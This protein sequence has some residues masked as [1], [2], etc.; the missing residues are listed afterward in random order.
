MLRP[1]DELTKQVKCVVWDLDNTLWRGVLSE[2]D[3]LVLRD[4]VLDT[5]EA[6][7]ARGVVQS[8]ASR[9]DEESVP[10]ELE[11]LGID[12]WFLYPQISWGAKHEALR[13]IATA[14]NLGLDTFLFVDDEP[15]ERESV[16]SALPEVRVVDSAEIGS[17]LD[18]P[19]L[20]ATAVTDEARRRRIM[21]QQDAER[22]QAQ[23][24]FA[25]PTDEFMASLDS[26]YTFHLA[27]ADDL[28]R[29]GELTVRTSQLNATGYT[30]TTAELDAFRRSDTH[31]LVVMDLTDRF[32]SLG[33]IGLVLLERGPQVWTIK[34]LLSSC[35]AM[36]RGAGTMLLRHVIESSQAAGVLLRSEFVR[37]DRNRMMFVAYRLG[38]FAEVERTDERLLLQHDGVTLPVVGPATVLADWV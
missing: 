19:D 28:E 11:R 13:R 31:T 32:G 25:G 4:G 34:L 36:A 24:N 12:Q 21:Y 3:S 35:R 18:R 15:F 8:I 29:A 9:N 2:G 14:L 27:E 20:A 1:H 30:Y 5:I 7:D 22:T 17:L 10:P 33:S 37:T 38:G 26:T 16:V 6:L 23:E